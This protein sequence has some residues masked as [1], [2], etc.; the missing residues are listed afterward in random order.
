RLHKS[1]DTLKAH[2]TS[3]S[4]FVLWP[5]RFFRA[6]KEF[7]VGA[8]Q[9]RFPVYSLRETLAYLAQR[10]DA[11]DIVQRDVFSQIHIEPIESHCRKLSLC[12]FRLLL[13]WRFK[14]LAQ[15][16]LKPLQNPTRLL[17]RNVTPCPQ[18]NRCRL[19]RAV[20][21]RVVEGLDTRLVDR[22]ACDSNTAIH[23]LP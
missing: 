12:D 2:T 22:I 10:F 16:P 17:L 6:N 8:C 7:L 19:I 5:K 23:K 20:S 18:G 13:S 3:G 1:S 14:Q 4:D 9:N 15:H 11:S 21:S